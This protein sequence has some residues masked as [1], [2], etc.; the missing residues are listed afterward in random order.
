M[1]KLAII[2]ARSGSRRIPRKN[3]RDF[4]GKPIIAYSIEAALDSSLFDRV[5]VSTDSEEIA[6]IASR[7]GAEVPFMRSEK[8]SNDFSGIDAVIL[9]VLKEYKA[10]GV[11]FDAFCCIMA[12]APLLRAERLVEAYKLM[13]TGNFDSVIPVVKFSYP[14][15]R[16]LQI[17]DR[18]VSM[19][20]P[21]N[22]SL[23]SQDLPQRYHDSAQFYWKLTASFM[24]KQKFLADNSGAIVLSEL[25]AQ[26]IDNEED[27]NLAELKYLSWKKKSQQENKV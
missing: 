20:N 17:T 15:Q 18:K 4:C 12:T 26:D 10:R 7:H 5:M 13:V 25:E 2:P 14:V 23:R 19:V 1:K 6:E 27:W 8:T 16:C 3:I 21:E 22:F 24:K 9:E 11:E